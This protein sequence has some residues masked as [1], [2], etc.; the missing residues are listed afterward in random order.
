MEWNNLAWEVI[1]QLNN[2]FFSEFLGLI[3]YIRNIW[4]RSFWLLAIIATLWSWGCWLFLVERPDLLI[5]GV[6][7]GTLGV[8]VLLF[9]W[10][11]LL[12]IRCWLIL[13]LIFEFERLRSMSSVPCM[14]RREIKTVFCAQIS[15]IRPQIERRM[16]LLLQKGLV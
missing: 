1:I 13:M 11:I 6:L 2:L 15:M 4:T 16:D 8:L 3:D 7:L 5:F 12:A 10:L 9:S 14:A